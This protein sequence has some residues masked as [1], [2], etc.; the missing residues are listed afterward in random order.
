MYYRKMYQQLYA[1][2]TDYQA[3]VYGYECWGKWDGLWRSALQA[4]IEDSHEIIQTNIA[5]IK[6][7]RRWPVEMD[8]PRDRKVYGNVHRFTRDPMTMTICAITQIYH[9]YEVRYL[10]E[11]KY[12][13]YTYSPVT[14]AWRKYLITGSEKWKRRYE[15]RELFNLK[16][17]KH[18]MFSLNLSAWMAYVAESEK[19]KIKLFWEHIPVWNLLLIALTKN[20]AWL[21][22]AEFETRCDNYKPK[23]RY[24]WCEKEQMEKMEWFD[25][26]WYLDEDDPVKLDKDILT[27][28]NEKEIT[29]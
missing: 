28:I 18:K 23:I 16:W 12:K 10:K 11:V 15:R 25:D 22:E 17:L 4:I 19:V 27:Y 7:D 14:H 26:S 5:L 24:Q 21:S 8:D 3:G 20:S 13:W 9:H 6:Q 29:Q 2:Q 1:P